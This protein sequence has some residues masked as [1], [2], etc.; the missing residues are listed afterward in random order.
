VVKLNEDSKF[1]IISM[2]KENVRKMIQLSDLDLQNATSLFSRQD[3]C[4]PNFED[5]II[6]T[7]CLGKY[8]RLVLKEIHGLGEHGDILGQLI[9][10]TLSEENAV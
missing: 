2:E 5:S 6:K 10:L 7:L 4:D 3:L 1:L 8:F 9:T